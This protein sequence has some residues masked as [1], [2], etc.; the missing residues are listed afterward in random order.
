M[1][2]EV[3]VDFIEGDP[4]R[5]IITGRVYN[6]EQM[7]PY[8]LPGEQTKSTL[9]S[10][11]SKDGTADNFNE[12]RFE[13]RKGEEEIYIHAE[14][15]QNRIVEN[16]DTLKVGFDKKD[17]GDQTIEIF[18]NQNLKVG[19]PQAPDGSQTVEIWKDQNTT[20]KTGDRN[21][22]I[23]MG[24]DSL[25]IEMGNRKTKVALGKSETEAMQS[26][27]LK[28]GKSSV[29]LDQMGVTIKGMMV[30]ING[31]TMVDIKGV[32]TKVTGSAMLKAKG[33][34]TMIN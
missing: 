19:D 6:A 4:D 9:K 14:K 15:D 25:E 5:P 31:R 29:K 27:E 33:G 22:K 11:S 10:R 18:N 30:K 13:D 21:V 2:Q 8:E 23:E 17:D 24:N 26:I 28:V 1:G 7:P 12:I 16:N 32:M 3:I 34:V 20:L